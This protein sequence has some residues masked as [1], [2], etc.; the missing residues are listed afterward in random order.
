MHEHAAALQSLYKDSTVRINI[1]GRLGPSQPSKTGLKQG[2]RLSPTLFGLF[3]DGLHRYL[4]ANCPELGVHVDGGD[5]LSILG[6]AYYFVLLADGAEGLQQLIDATAYFCV[7]IGMVNSVPEKKAMVF[8]A[9]PAQHAS[10]QCNGQ[11]LQQVDKLKYLGLLFSAEGVVQ[12]TFPLLKQKMFAACAL[13]KRQYGNL[14]CTSSVGLLLK[15]HDVC[16]PAT[17]T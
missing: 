10:W 4:K 16:V 14:S 2:W 6:Y 15:V 7:A 8:A 13:L 11:V 12:A 17:A 3:A 9:G 1:S 5:K